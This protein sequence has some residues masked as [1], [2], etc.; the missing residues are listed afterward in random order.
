MWDVEGKAYIERSGPAFLAQAQLYYEALEVV[1]DLMTVPLDEVL[2]VAVFDF[3]DRTPDRLGEVTEAP[4]A[5][6][7]SAVAQFVRAN[8]I[9]QIFIAL[10]MA[11]TLSTRLE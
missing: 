7:F 5:G 9:D 1:D 2:K 8:K 11:L 4:V 6:G 10:P 3:D